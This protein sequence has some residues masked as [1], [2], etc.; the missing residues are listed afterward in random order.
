MVPLLVIMGTLW[1]YTIFALLELAYA[2][3][4]SMHLVSVADVVGR[5][6][7]NKA[8]AVSVILFTIFYV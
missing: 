7:Q 5:I 8:F 6:Y 1:F 4:G 3:A 2:A